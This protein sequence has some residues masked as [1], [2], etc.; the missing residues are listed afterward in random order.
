VYKRLRIQIRGQGL[1][2]AVELLKENSGG[3]SPIGSTRHWGHQWHIVPDPGDYDDGKTGGPQD[4]SGR[5]WRKFFTLSGP[6][7]QLLVRPAC[8]QS[9]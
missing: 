8:S 7:L 5:R 3:W 4:R 1:V 2:K 9:L 6:E